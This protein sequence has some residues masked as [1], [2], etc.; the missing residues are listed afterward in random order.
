MA[1]KIAL[2]ELTFDLG[3]V[4]EEGATSLFAGAAQDEGHRADR[5]DAGGARMLAFFLP[6]GDARRVR[7]FS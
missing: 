5:V 1:A 7:Q 4:L 6:R 3:Q 2:E